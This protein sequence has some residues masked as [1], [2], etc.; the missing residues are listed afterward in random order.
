[1]KKDY[2]KQKLLLWPQVPFNNFWRSCK[3]LKSQNSNSVNEPI[4]LAHMQME[5]KRT[6]V[7][8]QNRTQTEAVTQKCLK[9]RPGA[10]LEGPR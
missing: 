2:F 6:R 3:G 10:L 8:H 1:M 7:Y 5:G 9:E 4:K